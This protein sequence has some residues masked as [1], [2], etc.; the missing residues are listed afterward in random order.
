MTLPLALAFVA[1]AATLA[2]YTLGVV[3][4]WYAL[5]RWF[6]DCIA[7]ARAERARR[8]RAGPG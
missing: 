3:W 8:T 1:T 4:A 7:H 2:L 6:A 5:G